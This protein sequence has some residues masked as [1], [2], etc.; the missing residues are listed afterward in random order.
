MISI[1][2]PTRKRSQRLEKLVESLRAVSCVTPEIVVYIDEDD[3]ES[4]TKAAE[5]NIKSVIGPKLVFSDYWN[6]CYEKSTGDI[7]MMAADDLIFRTP[8]WDVM[9]EEEF[10]KS[11]DKIILVCGND[12][13]GMNIPTHPILHRR[14]A[15]AVGY[16]SPPYFTHGACDI[17]LDDVA[18]FLG[19]KRFVNFIAEH[20]H[21]SVNK[22]ELDQTYKD[23]IERI[24]KYDVIQQYS[25]LAME[26]LS[27]AAKLQEVI[28]KY[29][30]CS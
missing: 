30:N 5:L 13:S 17:W 27:D 29:K 22:S 15:E 21:P 26:R 18:K 1:L 11:E 2:L 10:S 4:I 8:N 25:D 19:R 23:Q 3:S 14:W 24:Q 12:L 9:V 7:L 16:F 20:M 6:K 28:E